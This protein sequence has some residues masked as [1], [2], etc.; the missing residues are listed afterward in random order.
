MIQTWAHLR[1]LHNQ[2]SISCTILVA[3]EIKMIFH[4]SRLIITNSIRCTDISRCM[5]IPCTALR[6]PNNI[7]QDI[8]YL[9][10]LINKDII[11]IRRGRMD[12]R[13]ECNIR[14]TRTIQISSNKSILTDIIIE[15]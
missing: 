1:H 14:C 6:R 8:I 9:C 4:N 2:D 5:D 13:T 10:T 3:L 12:H 7:F 15:G 11:H